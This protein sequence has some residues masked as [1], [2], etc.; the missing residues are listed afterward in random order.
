MSH[1]VIGFQNWRLP[2]KESRQTIRPVERGGKARK[3]SRAPSCHGGP[4]LSAVLTRGGPL[5]FELQ[6]TVHR[7]YSYLFSC[8]QYYWSWWAPII[9]IIIL[10]LNARRSPMSHLFL[11][12]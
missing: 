8:Y 7:I 2:C 9:I 12:R 1:T 4:E 10:G 5:G 3:N 11:T 6:T